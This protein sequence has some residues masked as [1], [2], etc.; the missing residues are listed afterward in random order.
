MK[1]SLL[2]L[3]LLLAFP[4]SALAKGPST[5]TIHGPGLKHPILLTGK[6]SDEGSPLFRLVAD[7][8]FF[9]ATFGQSPDPMLH[10]RPAGALGPVYTIVWVLPGPNRVVSRVVQLV[11]PYAKRGAVSWMRSRQLFWRT[12]RTKGGWYPGGADLRRTLVS[13]GLPATA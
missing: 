5:A 8:G 12:N 2:V 13:L 3:A 11:Y 4:G 1:R 10:G 6:E 9:P 7:A